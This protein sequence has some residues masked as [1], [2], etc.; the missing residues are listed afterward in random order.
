MTFPAIETVSPRQ[1]AASAPLFE[2]ETPWHRVPWAARYADCSPKTIF[3]A[4]RS[5]ALR[6]ARVGGKRA[7]RLRV[8]WIDEWLERDAAPVGGPRP[9]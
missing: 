9:M 3:R 8:E 7:I 1:A 4:C 6:H 5:G 2:S